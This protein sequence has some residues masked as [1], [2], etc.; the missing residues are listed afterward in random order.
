MPANKDPKTGKWIARFYI[1]DSEGN[2][3]Q[4]KKR[5]FKTKREALEF[6]RDFINKNEGRP[7]MLFSDFINLFIEDKSHEWKPN[8]RFNNISRIQNHI[9]PFFGNMP[10]NEI[11]PLDIKKWQNDLLKKELAPST[12]NKLRNVLGSIFIYAVKYYDLGINP[13]EKVPALGSRK[14]K[15]KEIW[16]LEEYKEFIQY[17]D[18]PAFK[19]AFDTLYFT[20]LRI[21]E[22]TALTPADFDFSVPKLTVSKN[23]QTAGKEKFISTPKT[24]KSNREVILPEA[25][26][27]EIQEFIKIAKYGGLDQDERIFT[28]NKESYR[29]KM[30]KVCNKYG[31]KYISPHGLRH[32]H[33]SMLV[34]L[35]YNPVL[36]ADRLGHES[37]K[38]TLDTYSHLYSTGQ[39]VVAKK[40][41]ELII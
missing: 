36:I 7:S 3:K 13:C 40:L 20:G 41:N 35:G 19:V 17:I 27:K 10:L 33:T 6:E 8:T 12:L 23:Y 31:L 16:N 2:R 22:L 38:E 18:N 25:I 15:K 28:Y 30:R 5:G 24:S 1:T 29:N 14:A 9:L 32:S 39:E 11:K 37:I 21:G 34:E 4:K 26:A